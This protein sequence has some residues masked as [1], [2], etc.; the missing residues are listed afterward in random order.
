[1]LDRSIP[2]TRAR[3]SPPPA[4]PERHPQRRAA[5][6]PRPRPGRRARWTAAALLAAGATYYVARPIAPPPVPRPIVAYSAAAAAAHYR[7]GPVHDLATLLARYDRSG[8]G[9]IDAVEAARGTLA[10]DV[11]AI[12]N[13]S[14]M[15]AALDRLT[16]AAARAFVAAAAP[17]ALEALAL[18]D[19]PRDRYWAM[20]TAAQHLARRHRLIAGAQLAVIDA[21]AAR[22]LN[23]AEDLPPVMPWSAAA[24]RG[25]EVPWPPGNV[26]VAEV[27]GRTRVFLT[28]F[29]DGNFT[30]V[31]VHELDLATGALAAYPPGRP[32]LQRTLRAS[33]GIE[34]HGGV[35]Y[36]VDHGGYGIR[37]ARLVAV[38][39]ASDRV[40]LDHPFP[41]GLGQMPN[42]LAFVDR[43]DRTQIFISDT[44]PGRTPSGAWSAKSGIFQIDVRR[45]GDALTVLARRR[46]LDGDPLVEDGGLP[47]FPDRDRPAR[48]WLGTLAWGGV[49]GIAAQGNDVY[50]RR[51]QAPEIMVAPA[52]ALDAAHARVLDRF[53]FVDGFH[54]DERRVLWLGDVE[55]SAVFAYDL[56]TRAMV[57]VIQDRR[58][59][60]LDEVNVVGHTAYVT[61]SHLHEFMGE[62]LPSRRRRALAAAAPFF[63]YVIDVQPALDTIARLRREAAG[64]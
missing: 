6:P 37:D 30:D 40:L 49:D 61:A 26:A 35:L 53:P 39:L 27:G 5:L 62:L 7:V 31:Q 25:Y 2:D 60:W 18:A 59:H 22:H 45:D 36:V 9:S 19:D 51:M 33:L 42:D 34:A 23:G 32:A 11:A 48:S 10:D 55:G 43:P 20:P 41:I 17:G 21:G 28:P 52:D 4:S 1:M 56:T 38:D 14:E 8:D 57:K 16:P 47:M 64:E 15:L 46:H 3:R 29:P 58:L 63:F 13:P 24:V 44:A 12:L 50:F 54:V